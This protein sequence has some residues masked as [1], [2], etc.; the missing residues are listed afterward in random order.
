[1]CVFCSSFRLE[2]VDGNFQNISLT[3]AFKRT[4]LYRSKFLIG[5]K[6]IYL[7]GGWE[8]PEENFYPTESLFLKDPQNATEKDQRTGWRY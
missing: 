7:K 2:G 3:V 6:W 5:C 8:S 1:M 4:F